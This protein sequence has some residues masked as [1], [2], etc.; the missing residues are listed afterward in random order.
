MGVYLINVH[1]IGVRLM[2]VYLAVVHLMGISL[3]NVW[4]GHF[5]RELD[6]LDNG[7]HVLMSV[8]SWFGNTMHVP[9]VHLSI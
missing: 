8:D 1:L 5:L 9:C 6:A 4:S 7:A 3:I 2:G